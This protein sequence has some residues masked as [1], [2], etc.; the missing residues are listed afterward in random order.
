MHQTP[1]PE[2]VIVKLGGSLAAAP[3][4]AELLSGLATAGSPLVVVPGGGPLADAVRALQPRLSL[5]ED[6]CHHMAILAMESLALALAD[7]EPRLAPSADAPAMARAH[8]AGRAALWLPAAMARAADLPASWEV[9]SDSL[10]LWLALRLEARRLVLVKSLPAAGSLP[11]QWAQAG[12]VDPYF[13]PLAARYTGRI[14]LLSV[15]EALAAFSRD[16]SA[17]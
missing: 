7:I 15:D 14:D 11:S 4:L 5:S 3:R 2:A 8:A 6:A 13:P 9:T 10:A 12:L 16:R 1:M 17:A